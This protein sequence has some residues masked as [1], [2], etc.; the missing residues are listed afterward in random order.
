MWR[1]REFMALNSCGNKNGCGG[2]TKRG[3]LKNFNAIKAI[4]ISAIEKLI[5]YSF[6]NKNL[7]KEAFTH[8]SINRE[9]NYERM[10]F[11]G[12]AVIG[13]AVTEFLY[14][15]FPELNEGELSKY[16]ASLVRLENL[17]RIAENLNILKFIAKEK[18]N[19]KKSKTGCKTPAGGNLVSESHSENRRIGANVYEAVI[20]A[21]FL[22]SGYESAREVLMSHISRF[23]PN[24]LAEP[25]NNLDYK[26]QLQEIIQKSTGGTPEYE[27]IEK[28]GPDHDASFKVCVKIGEKISG[29]G[30]GRSK[31]IAE[32]AAAMEALKGYA[33]KYKTKK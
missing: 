9:L 26:T 29:H 16:R 18:D 22:D 33:L 32:Q 10:E 4:N 20:G 6:K 25:R 30:A 31:K 28:T 19:S 17:Y 14:L 2:G 21:I 5:G 11:L 12:D 8:K 27:T 24:D 1:L 15:D 7:A 3:V 13:A 23:S